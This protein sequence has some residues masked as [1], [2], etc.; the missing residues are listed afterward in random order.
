MRQTKP[1][2]IIFS[3]SVVLA[4][5][6][7]FSPS[8]VLVM[9]ITSTSEIDRREHKNEGV[10]LFILRPARECNKLRHCT[11]FPFVHVIACAHVVL[12]L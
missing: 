5:L 12:V 7:L 10:I 6:S 1:I 2:L 8:V 3:P 9:P 11:L 4:I